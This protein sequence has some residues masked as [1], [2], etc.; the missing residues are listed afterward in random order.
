[1]RESPRPEGATGRTGNGVRGLACV[2]ALLALLSAVPPAA[3]GGDGLVSVIVQLDRP[4]LARYGGDVPGLPATRRAATGAARLD[5]HSGRSRAYLAHLDDELGAFEITARGVAS[6]MRPIYRYRTVLG[7]VTLRVPEAAIPLLAGLPR[8]RAVYRD[9]VAFPDTE[10]SPR[11]IGAT[12]L[13]RRLGGPAGAGEGVVVGVLDTG[14]WPEHPSFADPDPGGRPYPPPPPTWNGGAGPECQAPGAADPC[15][16]LACSNKLIGAF[17]LL[18]TYKATLGLLPAE[19]D[20]ARD[21][22]GHGTHTSSTAAGNAGVANDID[23]RH[24]ISGIAPR[25]HVAMYR[26]CAEDGCFFS[27]S[28]AAIDQAVVDGVDVINFSIGGGANP[29]GDVVSLAFRDAYDAGVFV[30]ASAGNGGPGA[31]TVDHREPW[32]MTVGASTERR[33]FESAV[34]LRAADGQRLRARGASVTAGNAALGDVPVVL[35]SFLGDSLCLGPFSPGT[36]TRDELVVCERGV[37]ARTAKSFAVAQGGAG[38][39]ILYN[40][41]FEG[42]ATDN[43]FVPSIHLEA[44]EGAA[45]LDFLT[46]HG[47]VTGSLRQGRPHYAR[48]DVM[49]FFSS[50]GGSAQTLG[51]SKPDVTAPGVQI[52]AG[53][54]PQKHAF[55][56]SGGAPGH[57]FQ[58][59]QG[60]SMSSPHVAGAGALLRQLH[61]AWTPGQ[62]KSALMTTARTR[63]VVK[64]DGVTPASAFDMGSGRINLAYA[65]DPGLTFTASAQDFTD[66]V[67]DLWTTNYPSIYLPAIPGATAVTLQRVAHSEDDRDRRYRVKVR[68]PRGSLLAVTT[69]PARTL[70]VPANGDASLAIVV[71]M[72]ALAPGNLATATLELRGGGRRVHLPIVAVRGA[73]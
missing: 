38:G 14:I 35:A 37:S 61:P 45:A 64:E 36:F 44:D 13:W 8:V 58:A 26:V 51:I 25:A 73:P 4:P 57:L 19:C 68:T 43:H 54:T 32:V 63:R 7:G 47:G 17:E 34:T 6:S 10:R 69:D 71:D 23:P 60:T 29:Y 42:V 20:S 72:A 12:R 48:G 27:D 39:M 2:G 53:D 66:H 22:D 9:G 40:P 56:G 5:A 70:D 21:T 33:L 18:D 1:M 67:S 65:G 11:F 52:L 31:N 49:A 3:A 24:P 15:A 50:R 28:V 16:P 30:A 46:T 59:I 62:I 55:D 41:V